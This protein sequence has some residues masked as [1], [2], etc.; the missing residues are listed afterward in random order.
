[1]FAKEDIEEIDEEFVREE[2]PVQTDP[3]WK[4]KDLPHLIN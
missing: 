4:P 2:T 1:M 3:V